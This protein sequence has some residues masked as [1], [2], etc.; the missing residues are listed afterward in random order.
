MPIPARDLDGVR[1][2][3][4]RL[5]DAIR[6]LTDDQAREPS[7]LP[8]WSKG[9]VLTHVARNADSV[10]RRLEA[11]AHDEVVD[12]YVG[13]REGRTA[14]IEAGAGRSA[15]QLRAD[16]YESCAALEAVADRVADAVWD[17]PVRDISGVLRPA[18]TMLFA[19]WREVEVHHTDLGLGYPP[20]SWPPEIAETWL[21]EIVANLQRR[22]HAN[23]L[24]AWA[25]G[26]GPA[27]DLGPW[28]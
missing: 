28:A 27:P 25:L 21:P 18:A 22:T 15:S 8:G 9:H 20:S 2:S 14:D 19:R 3:H 6:A 24:L 26:R 16:V 7:L 10:T 23:S 11:A 1:A 12:Q 5:L 13:G 4:R 17:R